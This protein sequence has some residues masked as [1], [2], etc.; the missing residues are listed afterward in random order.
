MASSLF[1]LFGRSSYIFYLIHIPVIDFIGK[2]YIYPHF[3]HAGYDI[4]VMITFLITL[5]LSILLFKFYEHPMND[6]IKGWVKA[7]KKIAVNP[8]F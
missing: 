2:P 5:V 3:F 7:D 8:S 1:R 4:Y 6:W